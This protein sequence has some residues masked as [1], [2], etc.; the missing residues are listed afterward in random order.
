MEVIPTSKEKSSARIVLITGAT[1]GIGFEALLKL[2]ESRHHVIAPCRNDFRRQEIL[3]KIN[4]RNNSFSSLK[5]NVF[6]PIMDLSNIN[7]IRKSVNEIKSRYD[8]IDTL[9]LNAGMQ[10]TGA[11]EPRRSE[12]KFELTFAI[13][14]LAHQYLTQLIINLLLK[15]RFPRVIVTSSEVHNPKSAGGR[16]GLPAGLGNLTGILYEKNFSML[17][18][19]SEFSADKAYK[20]SKLCN[21]LFARELNRLLNNIGHRLP[22]LCWAPG[23]VIPR[24]SEGFFRYSRQFNEIG[25]RVFSFFARDLFR[26]TEN[27][28][29]AGLILKRLSVDEEFGE[30]DFKYYSNNLVRPGNFSLGISET[31][32]EAADQQLAIRL[33]N[34]SAE[35]LNISNQLRLAD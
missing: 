32:K 33:W 12:Q 5:S 10:Y 2:I 26:I 25:Q 1:S 18:G 29:R 7:S 34:R 30:P 13:N 16:I 31:S 22:I 23:L 35:L 24:T 19:K 11:K 28:N 14:H 8:H 20:D 21:I 9:A 27:V 6:M 3:F 4:K 17:D 15:S